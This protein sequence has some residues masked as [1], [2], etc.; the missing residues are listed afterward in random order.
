MMERLLLQ[1][2][3]LKVCLSNL[4]GD[5]GYPKAKFFLCLTN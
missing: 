2:F 5:S 1:S 3:D 4:N